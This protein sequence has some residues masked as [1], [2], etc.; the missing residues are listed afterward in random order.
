MFILSENSHCMT[1]STASYLIHG[2]WP[3]C[4]CCWSIC[5]GKSRTGMVLTQHS[6]SAHTA[7]STDSKSP[8]FFLHKLSFAI[9]IQFILC[10]RGFTWLSSFY[11]IKK[12]IQCCLFYQ[13]MKDL[14][15]VLPTPK[16]NETMKQNLLG[17][18]FSYYIGHGL[19]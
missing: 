1:L 15:V 19:M 10:V 13:D 3:F 6:A 17:S 9:Y 8:V 14:S 16:T 7:G 4:V 12:K 5:V 11:L 2:T 18:L